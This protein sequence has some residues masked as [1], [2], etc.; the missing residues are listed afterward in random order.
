MGA[1]SSIHVEVKDGEE[2]EPLGVAKVLQKV[3]EREKI[4]LVISGKQSID[5][6]SSQTGQILAGLL[7]WGQATQAS[8]VKFEDGGEWVQVTKEYVIPL[9]FPLLFHFNI[10][11][12][13]FGWRWKPNKE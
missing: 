13:Y 2:V 10:Y 7:G 3:V 5:D 9:T 6:D 12:C 11:I 8:A 4:N 1:D